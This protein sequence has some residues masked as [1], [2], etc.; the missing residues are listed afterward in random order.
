MKKHHLKFRAPI[1]GGLR[2]RLRVKDFGM[3]FMDEDGLH[4]ERRSVT[5]WQRLR[6][7]VVVIVDIPA[8]EDEDCEPLL[9]DL[10]PL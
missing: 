4:H 5:L 9:S 1:P 8:E 3:S 10:P 7:Y 2:E 6:G